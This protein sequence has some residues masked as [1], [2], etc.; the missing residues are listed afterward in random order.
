M[1]CFLC[2]GGGRKG[3]RVVGV[4]C[5]GGEVGLRRLLGDEG[6]VD[7]MRYLKG[8]IKF[9]GYL[10]WVSRQHVWQRTCIITVSC[11]GSLGIGSTMYRHAITDDTPGKGSSTRYLSFPLGTEIDKTPNFQEL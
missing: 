3:W 10:Y 1:C 11:L 2:L 8:H 4:F 9:I 5:I 6:C 7:C